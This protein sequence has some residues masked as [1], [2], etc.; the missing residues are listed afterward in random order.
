MLEHTGNENE[1]QGRTMN[2]RV[3]VIST[4]KT[5]TH[6]GASTLSA[7][8]PARSLTTLWLWSIGAVL[9]AAI[10]GIGALMSARV[11]DS[12]PTPAPAPAV[13]AR[14]DTQVAPAAGRLTDAERG[15]TDSS[16]IA[17]G[18]IGLAGVHGRWAWT[19]PANAMQ[20]WVAW[21]SPG[22]PGIY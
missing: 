8:P 5:H 17:A 20:R 7:G 6:R 10:I 3:G 16:A 11:G 1:G 2:G 9:V 15:L 18:L 22:L 14:S 21:V 4:S 13:V 12:S 19:P